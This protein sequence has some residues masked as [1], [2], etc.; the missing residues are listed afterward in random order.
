[1]RKIFGLL[2][3][4]ATAGLVFTLNNP[5]KDLPPLGPLIDPFNGFWANAEPEEVTPIENIQLANK[6]IKGTIYFDKRLVPHIYAPTDKDAFFLQGYTHAYYRIW[7][8]DLQTRAAAGRLSEIIGDKTLQFDRKQRRKG[9]VYAAEKTCAEMM[10]YPTTAAMLQAYTDGVNEYVNSLSFKNYPLEYKL[11]NSKPEPW[12]NLKTALL[13]KYMADDLTGSSDDLALTYLKNLLDS[14]HFNLWYPEHNKP[15]SPVIPRGT[16]FPKPTLTPAALPKDSNLFANIWKL[17]PSNDKETGKGSNNWAVGPTK[18]AHKSA[19][20]CNDPHLT[21]NLPS[22]WFEGQ[23]TTP[24]MNVY[25]ANLP[26]APGVV[27]GFN[28]SISWGLTNNYRDVKDF[29]AIKQTSEKT[30]LF[31][32]QSVPY[33]YRYEVIKVKGKPDYIDTVKYTVHGPVIYDKN[34]ASDG[35]ITQPIAM[36]WMGHRK[37]NELRAIYQLNTAKNYPDFC[38]AI[39][40]FICP[41]QNMLYAD[42]QGNIGLWGQGQ[43]VN[44]WPNQGKYLM[45]GSI[46]ATLWKD[47][48][49]TNENPQVLN[50]PQ[51]YLASANQTVTDSTYPYYYNGSFVEFRAQRINDLLQSLS[52]ASIEDMKHIQN[53]NYSILAAKSAP[54]LLNAIHDKVSDKDKAY[55]NLLK[56]WKYTLD[57][58]SKAATVFQLYWTF[59]Y[60]MLWQKQLP[61]VPEQLMPSPENTLSLILNAPSQDAIYAPIMRKAWLKAV[62]SLHK[63]ENNNALTWSKAKNTQ[64]NHLAKLP[65]FSVV[66]I[67]IGGWGNTI[68]AT[69]ITHGPSWKMI[70]EMG[71]NIVAQGVYPGGQSGNPG[72]K[73]YD[74]FISTWANGQY[75]PLQ[76]VPK[77]QHLAPQNTLIT[78]NINTN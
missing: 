71:P 9:M 72:S 1:M 58:D 16:Q 60:N 23:L 11:L 22:L 20:L 2:S 18:T 35:G 24:N 63:L 10:E 65:A 64:I 47:L 38:A 43:F 39:Q 25:G 48:I 42:K 77:A 75:F 68:N 33:Q 78:W 36:C 50:P 17:E 3:L 15:F 8:M 13:L 70:V 21:L 52:N 31:D 41:A 29:Y 34:Y 74:N 61:K 30:Y 12:T 32:N 57:K 49:P 45:N 7:Q 69:K 67:P 51:G 76:F 26:G 40:H 53:D 37:S 73:Y 46:S 28:D 27:I 5:I 6:G 59:F 66:N 54:I 62:D 14:T 44:K 4:T 56:D 55:Y 19:I